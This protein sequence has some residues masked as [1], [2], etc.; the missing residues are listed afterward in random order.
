M[1]KL[2][3]FLLLITIPSVY[4]DTLT[5]VI[6]HTLETNPDILISTN[7]RRAADQKLKQAQGGYWPSIE[8]TGGYG[9]ENSDNP[10]TRNR[11]GGDIT[12]TRQEIGLTLS[13]MLFD[14]FDVKHRVAQQKWLVN[15]AAYNVE[16]TS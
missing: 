13:Q 12:L 5:E 2:T 10:T 16:N 11:T 14:G 4:A 9:R 8:M 7:N 3:Y 1:I 6:Q 15:Y